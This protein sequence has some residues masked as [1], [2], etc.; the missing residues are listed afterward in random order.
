VKKIAL[1]AA[2]MGGTA[3]IAFGASGTFAAFT[4]T[5][6]GTG[7]A[8]AGT[9]DL[10]IGQGVVTGAL[11]AM[12]LNPGQSTTVAYWMNNTGTT[13]GTL[14]ADLTITEDAERDCTDA[15][16]KTVGNQ[17]ADTSCGWNGEGELADVA[18][19]QFLDATE[20]TPEACKAA[21]DGDA[22][23]NMG[24]ISLTD[25]AAV[26]ALG[27]GNLAANTGN[28]I[29]LKVAV[30]DSAGNNVQSDTMAFKVDVTLTQAPTTAGRA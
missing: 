11:P 13:N 12:S 30:P 23:L 22:V 16:Y 29:V 26:P 9:M 1:A 15:E 20:S 3:L 17:L 14:S 10:A 25:A 21:T 28:C 27:V 7:A 8:G 5:E 18:Q 24:L 6:T 4:D 2:A 19:V